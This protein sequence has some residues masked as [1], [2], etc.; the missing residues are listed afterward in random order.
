MNKE[1]LRNS[2]LL[3]VGLVALTECAK[4][5]TPKS[6]NI[7]LVFTDD[8]G[9]GDLSCYGNQLINTPNIDSMA[10]NGIMFTDCHVSSSVSTPSRAALMT[11]CNPVRINLPSVLFPTKS[12]GKKPNKGLNPEEETIAELLKEKGYAT[13]M[14]GKWHLGHIDKFM[15]I[16]QGFDTYLGLPYS[17]DMNIDKLPLYKDDKV[18]EICPEMGS[19]TKKYTEFSLDFIR[20][21]ANKEPFFLY[22]AHSMPHIPI[23]ASD[24]FKGHSKGGLYGDVIEEIDWSVGE[25]IKELK[26]QGIYENTLVIFMSDNGPWLSFGNHGGVTGP[27]REGKFSTFE[28]GSRVP[29]V[30]QFPGVI[31]AGTVSDQQITSMDMLPTLCAL[32]GSRLPE[33]K[34]DGMNVLPVLK[35]EKM[36]ILASRP[37]YYHE[38]E[39]F[40][41]VRVGD[42]KYLKEHKAWWILDTPGMDGKGGKYRRE[43]VPESLFNLRKDIG[44]TT[45]L[46]KQYPEKAAGL[47]KVLEAY[48]AEIA[49]ENRP[50]GIDENWTEE[51]K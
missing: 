47:K 24:D 25:I 50:C 32:T 46:I 27:L 4:K 21:K 13:A 14:A 23:G 40:Q 35:G 42:W 16:K 10:G 5:S 18:I 30:M 37:Y 1:I 39:I 6:P 48:E 44:E 8:Q 34:I 3:T 26:K 28:G 22:L 9:Y 7:I 51:T 43:I 49:V 12:W 31:P 2:L 20:E 17:N 15:P 36:K 33:K 45:N 19:L 11:G 38:N 29:C 41:G